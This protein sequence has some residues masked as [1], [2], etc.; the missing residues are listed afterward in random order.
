MKQTASIPR[1]RRSALK[2]LDRYVEFVESLSQRVL[3]TC[4]TQHVK[5][6]DMS[7]GFVRGGTS[8]ELD[9]CTYEDGTVLPPF[10]THFS[11]VEA[12]ESHLD[13]SL[14][15]PFLVYNIYL[16]LAHSGY[17]ADQILSL[18]EKSRAVFYGYCMCITNDPGI[19][20][21]E[22]D[23][24]YGLV[25]RLQAPGVGIYT[26]ENMAMPLSAA[27]FLGRELIPYSKRTKRQLSDYSME[28]LEKMMTGKKE[29]QL[30][31]ATDDCESL[32]FFTQ[33]A[34]RTW[35][36]LNVTGKTGYSISGGRLQAAD[37]K[38]IDHQSLDLE[39]ECKACGLF[40]E[41]TPECWKQMEA[42]LLDGQRLIR[43]GRL[44][45]SN[46]VGLARSAAANGSDSS[47]SDVVG[48]HDYNIGTYY[49]EDGSTYCFIMEGTA[50]LRQIKLDSDSQGIRLCVKAQDGQTKTTKDYDAASGLTLIANYFGVM[51]QI[52][53]TPLGH[54]IG[55]RG[56]EMEG[57]AV[58]GFQSSELSFP[59]LD[60]PESFPIRF[61]DKGIYMGMSNDSRYVGVL[62]LESESQ[63]LK[64]GCM[65]RGLSKEGTQGVG[66]A[67]PL[68]MNSLMQKIM[69]EAS[70]PSVSK[71][72]F[73]TVMTRWQACGPL[74]TLN[75]E[76]VDVKDYYVVSTM[77]CPSAPDDVDVMMEA[78][79]R[80]AEAYNAI[81]QDGSF[82]R[83]RAMGTGV[84]MTI[85]IP[86]QTKD[87]LDFAHTLLKALEKAE[88]PV[89]YEG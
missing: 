67:V 25:P 80:V 73:N 56:W 53:N 45:V 68:D 58:T 28:E 40:A 19:M 47:S 27:L 62:L 44:T 32:A 16:T 89:Q 23:M 33:C 51:T 37:W 71:E 35:E 30:Y 39:A 82:I 20:P 61:Y 70:P 9:G 12:Q 77:E 55:G 88:W 17:T 81:S 26:T 79:S 41:W 34:R 85:Y 74:S 59:T 10:V 13:R 63:E 21:Y 69:E 83:V 65:L 54:S 1:L 31:A 66:V 52:I 57:Q 43:S 64:A 86:K 29:Y 46:C 4:G 75:Q 7:K 3:S 15:I 87:T 49:H 42:I 76:D 36:R 8:W 78:K 24:K 72:V 5:I 84:H 22:R 14:P 18:D 2:D 60:S 6:P 38:P 48:G 50:A 11:L